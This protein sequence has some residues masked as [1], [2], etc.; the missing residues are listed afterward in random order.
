MIQILLVVILLGEVAL[1][2][3]VTVGIFL[4][5]IHGGPGLTATNIWS[6]CERLLLSVTGLNCSF[7]CAPTDLLYLIFPS[8]EIAAL[9]SEY[10]AST[11]SPSNINLVLDITLCCIRTPLL[12]RLTTSLFTG[13]SVLLS[14]SD[15][16]AGVLKAKAPSVSP[17]LLISTV[18]QSSILS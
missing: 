4:P 8:G 16:E 9:S 13:F 2:V 5:N 7:I 11:L 18:S 6:P 14:H 1:S 17:P 3:L 12:H 15:K 10:T